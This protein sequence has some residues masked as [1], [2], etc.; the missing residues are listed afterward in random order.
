MPTVSSS[1]LTRSGRLWYS[2]V[3][4]CSSFGQKAFLADLK[5]VVPPEQHDI[6]LIGG[7]D[8]SQAES[9]DGQHASSAAAK[10]A[11]TMTDLHSKLFAGEG[12]GFKQ[13]A[14]V[15]KKGEGELSM[16][17]CRQVVKTNKAHA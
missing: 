5:K 1:P 7:A 11:V 14:I 2:R 4:T 15:C 9:Q 6:I 12:I 3:C 8:A 16:W 17:R 13:G 10:K